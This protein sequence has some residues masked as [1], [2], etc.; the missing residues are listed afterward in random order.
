MKK[1]LFLDLE[2]TVID[3]WETGNIIA[4]PEFQKVKEYIKDFEPDEIHI[5][6]YAIW[7]EKDEDDF[8][9]IHKVFIEENFDIE[10]N[11]WYSIKHFISVS[12][13]I[14][15]CMMDAGD[16]HSFNKKQVFFP[17]FCNEEFKNC[18]CMLLDDTVEDDDIVFGKNNCEVHLR[19][20]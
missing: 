3:A 20:I 7:N 13:K 1:I 19:K 4:I 15:K 18:R 17:L 2:G 5:F 6:S 9:N 16:F 14:Y 8:E 10:I 12:E 11:K